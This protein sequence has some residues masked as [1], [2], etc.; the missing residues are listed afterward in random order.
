MDLIDIQWRAVDLVAVAVLQPG[1][2]SPLV[3]VDGV[4]LAGGAGAGLRVEGVGVGLVAQDPVGAG[5]GEL[6]GVVGLTAGEK[7]LPDAVGDL[8]HGVGV[9][10]PEIEITHYG[11]GQGPRRPYAEHIA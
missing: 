4:E 2:V 6:V 5:D 11:D 8:L 1:A 7:A 9:H 10:I 3:A